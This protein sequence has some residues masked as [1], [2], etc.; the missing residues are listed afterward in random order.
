MQIQLIP[1]QS[2][3]YKG[4]MRFVDMDEIYRIRDSI[5]E[6]GLL[7]P[8]TVQR[9]PYDGHSDKYELVAG[10]KRLYCMGL[11]ETGVIPAIVLDPKL[12]TDKVLEIH[13]HENL[14]RANLPWYEIVILELDLHELR[15]KQHGKKVSGP[16]ISGKEQG[17]S[18]ADTARELGIAMGGLSQDIDLA[19]ALRKNPHLSKVKDKTTAIQLVR[20]AAR[21]E[22]AEL[23]AQLPSEFTMNQV[24]LGDSLEILREMPPNLFD[25]CITDPPWAEYKDEELT[26]DENTALVFKEIYRVLKPNSLLY[27]I[28]ASDFFLYLKLLPDFGFTVQKYP[29][30]WRKSGTITHGRAPWQYARDFELII[31]AAKGRPMLTSPTEIS[32]IF[33]FP[34]LHSSKLI[35]PNEKPIELM[36]TLIQHATFDGSKVLDPFAG[37]GVTLEAARLTV[38]EYIGIE[39]DKKYFDKIVNRLSK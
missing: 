8:I 21:R 23:D 3:S 37:S 17:W 6:N 30:I 11:L 34:V 24:F 22:V 5:K 26:S 13:L 9:L 15:V 14:R 29:L 36:K 4:N 31:L 33:D 20:Q 19:F 39:R 25:A 2:I 10:K 16:R 32:A 28:V 18:Q 38:R 7:H 35:H 1:I 12:S 27:A